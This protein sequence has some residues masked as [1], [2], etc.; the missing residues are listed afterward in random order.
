MMKRAPLTTIEEDFK[1]IGLGHLVKESTAPKAESTETV[2]TPE[3]IE[4]VETETGEGEKQGEPVAEVKAVRTKRHTASDRLKWRRAKKKGKAKAASRKYRKKSSVKRML[5]RHK[6]RADKLRHGKPAG[7]RRLVFGLDTVSNLLEDVQNIVSALDED[8]VRN[9]I[10]TFANISIIAE[11]LA[12]SF[13]RFENEMTEDED[14]EQLSEAAA[15]FAE[16]A[17]DA[18]DLATALNEGT[19]EID[20]DDVSDMFRTSM[21]DLLNGLE[22]YANIT[23]DDELEGLAGNVDED[24]DSDDDDDDE[25]DLVSEEDEDDDEEEDDE[26]EDEDDEEEGEKKSPFPPKAEGKKGKK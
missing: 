3:N 12:Q 20:M 22:M 19:E 8:K 25:D 14:K 11:M 21:K 18:A 4:S 9:A 7:R 17:N 6:M 23:E 13:E 24:D 15:Y 26:D 1:A 5:K 16:L 10:K 2:V